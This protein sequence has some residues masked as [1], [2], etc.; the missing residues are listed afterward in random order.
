MATLGKTKLLLAEQPAVVREFVAPSSLGLPV[1]PAL[2]DLL[3]VACT[4]MFCGTTIQ[5]I[6]SLVLRHVRWM[7]RACA[8]GVHCSLKFAGYSLIA[9][10]Y[11]PP[12][13]TRAI[14][15]RGG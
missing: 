2:F 5:V 10:G 7:K 1:M 12:G 14:P 3:G 8:V 13:A 15:T 4:V 9:Q 6:E 11:L